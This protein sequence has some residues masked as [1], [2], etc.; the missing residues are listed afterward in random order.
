[1][2]VPANLI[3]RIISDQLNEYIVPDIYIERECQAKLISLASN[4]EIIVLTGIRRCGKSVLM[5]QLRQHHDKSDYYFNFEDE[6]LVDFTVHDFQTLQEV[7][8]ELFGIQKTYYFDEIQNIPGWEMFIRRLYNA[9]YKIYITGSNAN[10]FSE[11]LGTRLT[12]RYIPV[13]I[14]PLS[15]K[16]YLTYY[17][18]TIVTSKLLST[19]QI[20]TLNKQLQDYFQD[21]GIPEFVKHQQMDYLHAL[22]ESILYRDIIARYKISNTTAIKKLVFYLASNCSKELTYNSLRK[23]LGLGSAT[24]VS[25]YCHYLEGSFLCFFIHRYSDSVKV[26]QQSPKKI[27]FCDHILAKIVGF[28]ISHDFGRMLE[29]IVFLELKRREYDVFY[30]NQTKECDFIVRKGSQTIQ[31]IQVCANIDH[32]ETKKR[33]IDGLIEALE[34]FSITKGI[35]ITEHESFSIQLEKE[36]RQYIIDAIPAAQWLIHNN[37]NISIEK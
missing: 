22:Y 33:E 4:P 31:A 10:L 21:G 37:Q 2:S 3:K 9:G 19:I 13:T 18:P 5:N 15:F 6:R 24:T 27:Y 14:Y 11:E 17:E 35:I 34:Y 32:P 1:M 8:I 20:G 30:Y 16:E 28:R 7:F 12:G 36:G 29:N 23:F 25:D 26:Q